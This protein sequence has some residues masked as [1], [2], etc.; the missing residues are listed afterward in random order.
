MSG[1]YGLDKWRLDKQMIVNQGKK[2]GG[3]SAAETFSHGFARILADFL[4]ILLPRMRVRP[5]KSTAGG[6][7]SLFLA[8]PRISG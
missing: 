8:L 1:D 5:C 7:V 4:G 6:D 3:A 2:Q